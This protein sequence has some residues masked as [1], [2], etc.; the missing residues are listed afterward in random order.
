MSLTLSNRPVSLPAQCRSGALWI[1]GH[2]I[3]LLVAAAIVVLIFVVARSTD[4]AS[5][6]ANEGPVASDQ[7]DFA[8]QAQVR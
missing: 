7:A 8:P 3:R 2:A 1:A 5:A 4:A 6:S